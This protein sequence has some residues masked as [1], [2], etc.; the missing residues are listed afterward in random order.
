MQE[1]ICGVIDLMQQEHSRPPASGR[2]GNFG[3][4]N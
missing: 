1:L 3:L 2:L 4:E